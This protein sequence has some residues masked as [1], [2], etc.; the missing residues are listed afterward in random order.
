MFLRLYCIL[1]VGPNLKHNCRPD[2][3]SS[4]LE[5]KLNIL[6]SWLAFPHSP[7]MTNQLSGVNFF[8]IMHFCGK[9]CWHIWSSGWLMLV[10]RDYY[11]VH[12]SQHIALSIIT[13]QPISPRRSVSGVSRVRVSTL[14]SCMW[15]ISKDLSLVC[16]CS[17]CHQ[18]NHPETTLIYSKL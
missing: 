2:G 17:I 15:I 6:N 5:L 8:A 4:L 1:L 11:S 7:F 18:R 10:P 12:L 9:N 13:S 16:H 14:H 3:S